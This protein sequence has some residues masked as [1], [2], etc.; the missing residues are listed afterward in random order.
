LTVKPFQTRNVN[1]EE[2]EEEEEGIRGTEVVNFAGKNRILSNFPIL[3]LSTQVR[4]HFPFPHL[5]IHY[6]RY[7]LPSLFSL[8]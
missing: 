1:E 5:H 6:R 2:E 3:S 7:A 8:H 4:V